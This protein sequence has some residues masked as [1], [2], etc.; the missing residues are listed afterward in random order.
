MDG[1]FESGGLPC[2]DGH[3]LEVWLKLSCQKPAGLHFTPYDSLERPPFSSC[4]PLLGWH[5]S[6]A[7]TTLDWSEK[8]LSKIL[9]LTVR[10]STPHLPSL[11]L[12]RPSEIA[13]KEG[14]RPYSVRKKAHLAES[15]RLGTCFPP[16][17]SS[18]I[19]PSSSR[20]YIQ[21]LALRELC[22]PA[23]NT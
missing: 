2:S 19:R 10:L 4:V 18:Q 7:L 14:C 16:F 15:W 11:I 8:I 3:H 9:S 21:L 5:N 22:Q 13:R 17:F 1:S 20:S 6:L 23:C 12:N